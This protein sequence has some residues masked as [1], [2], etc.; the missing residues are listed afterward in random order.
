MRI[1]EVKAA[2]GKPVRF[3][4]ERLH[5]DGMYVLTGCII[6]RGNDGFYYQAEIARDGHV[7]IA[8]LEEIANE[9]P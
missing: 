5:C 1:E 7:I 2:L 6:R 4:N 8:R 3:R 9:M